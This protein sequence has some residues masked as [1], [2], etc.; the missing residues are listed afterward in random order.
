MNIRSI[1]LKTLASM[2]LTLGMAF[3]V[4]AADKPTA[5]DIVLAPL[6]AQAMPNGSVGPVQ[7]QDGMAVSVLVENPDGTLVPKST[8]VNFPNGQRFRLK[9]FAPRDGEVLVYNTNPAGQTSQA[10]VWKT[11]VKAG[12]ES[13]SEPFLL[14]GTQGEDLLHVVLQPKVAPPQGTYNWFQAALAANASGKA[15]KDIVLVTENTP[16]TTFFYNS[17]GQGG[18]VTIHFRHQ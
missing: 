6:A 14:S 5:K 9:I 15:S 1:P 11:T 3:G 4:Q 2:A 13:I 12:L 18:Y 10:P 7:S 8:D 16:Q 17:G